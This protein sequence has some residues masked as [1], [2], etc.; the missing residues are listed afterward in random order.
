MVTGSLFIDQ[1]LMSNA[2][3]NFVTSP[4]NGDSY[5]EIL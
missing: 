2:L 5:N 4:K 1:R 3:S